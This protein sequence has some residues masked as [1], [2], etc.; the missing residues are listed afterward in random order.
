MQEIAPGR[1]FLNLSNQSRAIA[2]VLFSY[3][4]FLVV[5][6]WYQSPMLD[7]I[8]HFGAGVSHW[9]TGNFRLYKVN[10]P[11]SR[12]VSTLPAMPWVKLDLSQM[13]KDQ[14]ARS[15]FTVGSDMVAANRDQLQFIFAVMRASNAVFAVLGAWFLFFWGTRIFGVTAGWFAMFL[16]MLDPNVIAWAASIMPDVPAATMG[17]IAVYGIHRSLTQET[18]RTV[19]ADG[20]FVGLAMLTKLTWIVLLPALAG[21]VL[22][23]AALLLLRGGRLQP[24]VQLLLKSTVLVIVAIG[25]VN[26]GYGFRG[27]GKEL[28]RFE[29]R[30]SYFSDY[31]NFGERPI[32]PGN[33]FKNQLLS[34]LPVPV[35]ESYLL[36]L[37]YIRWEFEKSLPSYLFGQWKKDGGWWYFYLVAFILKE[38]LIIQLLVFGA[39]GAIALRPATYLTSKSLELAIILPLVSLW[40]I[41]SSQTGFTHHLRY[42]LP[43]WPFMILFIARLAMPSTTQIRSPGIRRILLVI[44][45]FLLLVNAAG[46]FPWYVS[47]FNKAVTSKDKSWFLINSNLDFGQGFFAL[48]DYLNRTRDSSDVFY[49]KINSIS[50]PTDAGLFLPSAPTNMEIVSSLRRKFWAKTASDPDICSHLYHLLPPGRYIVT[51]NAY[52]SQHEHFSYFQSFHPAVTIADCL[53][54]F[55]IRDQDQY[56]AMVGHFREQII[57]RLGDP[58]GRPAPMP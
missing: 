8:A 12:L 33:R 36:G 11:L 55:D 32:A 13:P 1:R 50:K 10:P 42:I 30:S 27:T 15:E 48:R 44:V 14:W 52:R 41:V 2:L 40:L 46:S 37:D 51:A 21:L 6:G 45:P 54:V 58:S 25:V 24:I 34:Q 31:D 20:I 26:L 38:P 18:M 23:K 17:L 16:W 7:E 29:F 43:A 39:V 57:Y 4:S 5:V 53:F 47:H 56:R 19:L 49:A 3:W 22:S 9:E 28:K 35:P